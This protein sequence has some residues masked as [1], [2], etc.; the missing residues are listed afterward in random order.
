MLLRIRR[1]KTEP[2][3]IPLTQPVLDGLRQYW[4][5]TRPPGPHL[6]PGRGRNEVMTRVGVKNAL[7][8]ACLRAGIKKHITPHSLRHAY[9]THLMDTGADLRT[10]QVLLGHANPSSTL[11]YTRL[12]R[13]RLVATP[14]PIE[15]LHDERGRVLG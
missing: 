3:Y 7:D 8:A 13:A 6:F 10:V 12:S 15:L 14:S 4:S 5:A 9:A 1:A 2:R 11:R